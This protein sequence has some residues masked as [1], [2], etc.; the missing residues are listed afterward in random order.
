VCF[1]YFGGA[2]TVT[3]GTFTVVPNASGLFTLTL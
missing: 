3:L 2:Q 1:L